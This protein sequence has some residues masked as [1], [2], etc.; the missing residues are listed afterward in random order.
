[1]R[2]PGFVGGFA[3]WWISQSHSDPQAPASLP[4]A[5][6]GLEVAQG[7]FLSFKAHFETLETWH[8]RQ[9]SSLLKTKYDKGMGGVFQDLRRQP[10][11]RLDFLQQTKSFGILATEGS[12]LHLDAPVLT[13]GTSHWQ[14]EDVEISTTLVNEVVL[15]T[16]A[17]CQPGDVLV[18]HQ[19]ISDVPEIHAHLLAYWR[20]TW[21]ALEQ[22]D[23]EVWHRVQRFTEAFVPRLELDLPD[24]TVQDWRRAL[25][26]FKPT[27][28]RG[29][30]GISHVDLLAMPD[31]WIERLLHFLRCIESG[32]HSWPKA[33]LYGVVSV[34][35]KD[36][37]ATTI[38]RFRPIVIFSVIYR[39]WASI[40][41]KQLLRWLANHM[42]CEAYGFIPGCEPSQLWAVL[43]GEIECSLLEDRPLCGLSTDLIRAFN[44]IPRQ[45]TFGLATHLGVPSK[46]TLPWRSFLESC[47]RSFEVRGSLSE[48]T[49][50]HCG[51][52]EGDALSVYAMVQL[53]F[54]WHIY[55]RAFSPQVRAISFVDNLALVAAAPAHL[56]AG[57]AC[58]IEFFKL[59]N[60]ATEAAKSYCWGTTTLLRQQ[61]AA[62]PFRCVDSAH[63][64]GGVMSFTK[65]PGTG[66]QHKRHLA[67]ET[68]WKALQKSCAPLRQKLAAIPLVFWASALHGIYGYCHGETHLEA[69][70]QQAMVSLRLRRAGVNPLLR[71]TL[72]TT[73]DADPGLWRA[74]QVVL[75]LRRLAMKEPRFLTLWRFFMLRNR[76]ELFS[77]PFSQVLIVFS[78]LGWHIDPPFFFDHDGCQHHLLQLDPATLASLV[79][80]GWLQH[81]ARQVTHRNT[82]N[83]LVGIDSCLVR[84]GTPSLNALET[85]LLGALQSGAFIG[86]ASHSK[87]DFTK[88]ANCSHCQLPD[89]PAHWLV[90][91]CFQALRDGVEGWVQDHPCDTQAL[92]L[93]LLPSRSPFWKPW[94]EALLAIEDHTAEF[95]SLPAE[96]VNHLFTDGSASKTG[97]PFD[98]A[99]WSVTNATTGQFVATGPSHGLCQN[100]DR[101]E[102][103]AVLSALRWRN[104]HRIDVHLW[105]DAQYVVSGLLFLLQHG[106]AGNWVHQDLWTAIA[107][108]IQS[109]P[110]HSVMPHWIPSHL[111]SEALESPFED[112]VQQH[113]DRADRLAGVANRSRPHDLLSLQRAAIK[114]HTETADRLRQLK[115]FYFRVAAQPK[116]AEPAVL[117]DLT[118]PEHPNFD[119]E[120]QISLHDVYNSDLSDLL[121]SAAC[122]PKLSVS[123]VLA[124]LQW[125]LDHSCVDASVYDLSYEELA[126]LL[127]ADSHFKFPFWSPH[128][129][130]MELQLLHSRFEKVT[131]SFFVDVLRRSLRFLVGIDDGF[132]MVLF[133][134]HSKVTMGILRPASGLFL[135]LLPEHVQQA[136]QR[137][138]QFTFSRQIRKSCDLARPV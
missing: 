100:S 69:L 101:A 13:G 27:A 76:G 2:S 5:P 118:E 79:M 121:L 39:T 31:P 99:S 46:V 107:D 68:R 16:T 82:M 114:Y 137:L 55:M 125:L 37:Q 45:H 116:V 12:Q 126:L 129:G 72:S 75:S 19:T 86:T 66:L 11:D 102:L 115:T 123:F 7:V 6:P 42:D 108:E 124:L 10:R 105:I 57:L 91:P 73:P 4:L 65:R 120:T 103:L 28:A 93:H 56:V 113:N 53:N 58:L 138:Q 94:K 119:A 54:A 34:I 77:G 40:R 44:H 35:A 89:A 96:G 1:M 18:Q 62:L 131:L 134:K 22:V 98:L 21:C 80:D 67:L 81:I 111:D 128:T 23:A 26:R 47:S 51:L 70:R 9:R 20:R 122:P 61:L 136:Q 97:T 30:D 109:L 110:E 43:Q 15:S 92:R 63:E 38:D 112:W 36:V 90:C 3:S 32:Q 49:I 14:Y 88:E 24:I 29:V 48:S 132:R 71:L 106:V 87:F 33:L 8:L 130:A 60:L 41:S 85:S 127:A 78:Q 52:P 83:D 133:D 74:K 25:R 64:L 59:W 17:S 104:T 50:S 135:R 117:I 95:W 84:V